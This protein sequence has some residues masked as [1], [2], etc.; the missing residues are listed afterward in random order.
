VRDRADRK[1]R[2]DREK[3]DGKSNGAATKEQ[4]RV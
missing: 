1:A 3:R 4:A 2:A